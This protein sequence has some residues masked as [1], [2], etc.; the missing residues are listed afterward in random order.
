MQA[1]KPVGLPAI[2]EVEQLVNN[3]Q[4]KMTHSAHVLLKQL[5]SSKRSLQPKLQTC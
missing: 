3:M 1:T 5:T 2:I 4:A